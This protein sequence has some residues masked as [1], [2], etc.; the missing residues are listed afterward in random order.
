MSNYALLNS[1]NPPYLY[2]IENAYT[3]PLDADIGPAVPTD[4][5]GDLIDIEIIQNADGSPQTLT[6]PA[7]TYNIQM[8]AT[9]GTAESD[10]EIYNAILALVD[11]GTGNIITITN[12]NVLFGGN[13]P[14]NSFA[15]FNE[16]HRIVL[17]S[18]TV[19]RLLL[20]YGNADHDFYMMANT[21]YNGYN[22]NSRLL[23]NKTF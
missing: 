19:V 20:K 5:T 11:N 7:G 15:I 8:I 16:T 21:N 22:Q 14:T 23:V 9:I 1:P 18:Q 6:L 4:I 13:V 17:T 12:S 2:K 10:A 3:N